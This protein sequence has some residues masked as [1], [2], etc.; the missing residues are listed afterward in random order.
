MSDDNEEELE[1]EFD[2]KKIKSVLAD[3][4]EEDLLADPLVVEEV[5]P[6]ELE[7]DTFSLYENDDEGAEF[8]Y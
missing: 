2:L 8:S 7:D 3:P 1:E 4:D 6:E 5:D